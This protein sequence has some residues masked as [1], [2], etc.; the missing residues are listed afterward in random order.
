MNWLDI[1]ILVTLGIVALTGLRM[2]GVHLG[3]AAAGIVV[4]IALASRLHYDLEPVF[5]PF[6]DSEDG[7]EVA[8]F[9][10]IFVLVLLV[11][12]VVAQITRKILSSVML[13]WTD[14]VAGLGL[15]VVVT[16]AAGSAILSM[17]Q[18]HPV[19]GLEATIDESTMGSFLADNFDTVLRGLKFVPSDLGT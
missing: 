17:V 6:I 12:V 19:L 18:S 9:V 1:V 13:G 2:G 16:F 8:A 11:S 3:V 15:G 10:A 5:S 7:A 4:G 14:K